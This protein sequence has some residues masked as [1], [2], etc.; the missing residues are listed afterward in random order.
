MEQSDN[1]KVTTAASKKL[2]TTG[3]RVDKDTRRI[4]ARILDKLNKKQFGKRVK[5]NQL[6]ALAIGLLNDDHYKQLQKQSLSN[7]DKLEMQFKEYVRQHGSISKDEF[8]GKLHELFI[9]QMS[10]TARS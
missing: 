2:N 9:G 8:L 5:A 4:I 6:I 7:A 3:I 1:K 10:Q